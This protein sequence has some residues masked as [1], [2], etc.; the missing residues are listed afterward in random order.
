MIGHSTLKPQDETTPLEERLY[1]C[2][3]SHY[4]ELTKDLILTGFH[5]I[6]VDFITPQDEV[7]ITRVLKKIYVTDR[8]Y[9]LPVCIDERASLYPETGSHTIWH[10]A[11]ENSDY[12]SNYGIYANGLLVETCSKRFIKELSKMTLMV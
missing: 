10:L 9:R 6:L 12:Y 8:K 5:A 2:K 11:L 4:P 7:E 3:P 1:I